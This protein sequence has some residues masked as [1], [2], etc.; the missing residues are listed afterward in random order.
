M[1]KV[2]PWLLAVLAGVVITSLTFFIYSPRTCSSWVGGGGCSTE[3]GYPAKYYTK[4]QLTGSSIPNQPPSTI[5]NFYLNAFIGDALIWSIFSLI[6]VGLTRITG[7]K[8]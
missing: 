4:L 8:K 1:S 2:T 6:L 3:Y 7:K 5:T